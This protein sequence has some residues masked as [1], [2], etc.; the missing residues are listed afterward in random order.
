METFWLKQGGRVALGVNGARWLETA[1]PAFALVCFASGCSLL[2]ARR[3]AWSLLP[4][5]VAAAI[6]AVA[7][8]G[9]AWR[10]TRKKWFSRLDGLVR[11]EAVLGL[12]NRLSCAAAGVGPWPPPQ[13]GVS[14]RFRWRW[15]RLAMPVGCGLVFLAAAFW[16]PITPE[17]ILPPARIEQPLALAQ[18]EKA[19]DALK[20]DAVADPQALEAQEQKLE[21]LRA[22]P[23]EAWYS[24]GGLEASDALREKT[25][26]DIAALERHLDAAT[27]ALAAMEFSQGNGAPI[28]LDKE[29]QWNEAMQGLQSGGMPLNK[30][31]LSALTQCGKNALSPQQ[32]QALREKLSQNQATCRAAMQTVGEALAQ[33]KTGFCEGGGQD[34][35]PG[36][37]GGGKTAPLGL[38]EKA[39]DIQPQQEQRLESKDAEHTA[40]GDVMKVTTGSHKVDPNAGAAPTAG[41]ATASA[42]AGGEAVW[43]TAASPKEEAVLRKYFE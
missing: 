7:V 25:G 17:P 19:L 22:Q 6:A 24:Q 3:E 41:G 35:P 31:D 8:A 20:R 9:F 5:T 38:R 33:A 40:L 15:Q 43:K 26:H 13:E 1:A 42:G 16:M 27:Q 28:A 12:H 39:A 23:P 11:L 36:P 2:L 34:A 29:T 21:A 37:G 32:L 4:V 10:R 30:A 14:G 18:V